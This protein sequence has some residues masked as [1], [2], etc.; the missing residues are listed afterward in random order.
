MA[1]DVE[2]RALATGKTGA[3]PRVRTPG[4]R[5]WQRALD[6]L[7]QAA[8]R[9]HATPLTALWHQVADLHQRRE[10][11]DGLNRDAAPGVDGQPWAASGEHLEANLRALSDRRKR[12]A[13]H[14]RPVQR[15]DIP[16]PEGRQ[17]ATVEVLNAI[18][19]GELRGCA[20]GLRPGR[21]PQEALEAVTGGIEKRPGNGVLEADI[22]GVVE[23]IAPAGLGQFIEQRRGDQR[24]VHPRQPWRHAGV[25]AEGPWHAPVEGTRPGGRVRP[26]AANIDRP[27]GLDLWADRWRRPHARGEVISMRYAAD[28]IGGGEHGDDAERFGRARRARRGQC[29]LERPPEKTPLIEVGRLAAERRQRRAQGNPATVDG[30]GLTPTGRTTRH[31]TLTVRRQ[32]MA[33]RRRRPGP[34]PPPGAWLQRGLLGPDRDGAVPRH[35]RRL[36]VCRDPIMRDW[37]PTRRRRRQRPRMTWP[38]LYARAEPWLPT[39]PI[40]PP[41]PAPR[42]CVTTRGRSPGRSCRTPGSVRGVLGHRHPYRDRQ[43]LRYDR[44][45]IF[46]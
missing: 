33:W 44:H 13:Y 16:T 9:D 26:V 30:R 28:V 42:L 34:L 43:C 32:T 31:G 46:L 36:T 25:R 29:H 19:A 23:A 15:V 20:D 40:L 12:G 8:R 14:A 37:C 1:A 22:R 24:V 17:R 11:S 38:R 39:P 27:D 35:G 6:R 41:Y 18:D 45:A 10:A 21:R 5:A 4:R 2:G 3:Q 7:R